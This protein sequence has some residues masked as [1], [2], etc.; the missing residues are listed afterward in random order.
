MN[1]PK[2]FRGN[3]GVFVNPKAAS[4][5]KKEPVFIET[6]K[7]VPI[8][9]PELETVFG[10]IPVHARKGGST[11]FIFSKQKNDYWEFILDGKVVATLER[12]E[13][14]ESEE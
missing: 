10:S 7:I 13:K 14:L 6:E 11:R 2:E 5:S 1:V 12:I 3:V 9:K 4:K 8:P